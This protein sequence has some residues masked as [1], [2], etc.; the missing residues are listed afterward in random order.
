MSGN[1]DDR[2]WLEFARNLEDRAEN[3]PGLSAELRHRAMVAAQNLRA[4]ERYRQRPRFEQDGATWEGQPVFKCTGK[5]AGLIDMLPEFARTGLSYENAL[6]E[7]IDLIVR[8]PHGDDDRTVPVSTVSRRYALI[9]HRD[10]VTWVC[11][12]FRQLNWDPAELD[13]TMRCSEYGERMSLRIPI[14]GMIAHVR[15][16][17]SLYPEV[18]VWNSVDRTQAMEVAIGWMRLI[19]SNGLGVWEPDDRLRKIHH[20]KLKSSESPVKFLSERLLGNGDQI[21]MLRRWAD[22]KIDENYLVEW[23]DHVVAEQWGKVR[24]ARFLHIAKTGHDCSVGQSAREKKASMLTTQSGAPVP[25]APER[26]DNA[27]DHYQTLL[28]LAGTERTLESREARIDEAL[29]LIRSLLP[30]ELRRSS[31]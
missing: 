14:P 10:L 17:D 26:S 4:V 9:Q 24:A 27:Y 30:P 2:N 3:Q 1:G 13:A 31:R 29:E 28:W 8:L 25:G 12:A 21:E 23:V 20:S 18:R 22:F 5:L 19:C 15:K 6:N 11:E 7:Y 16:G